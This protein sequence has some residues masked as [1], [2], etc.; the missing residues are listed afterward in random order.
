MVTEEELR[1]QYA[2]MTTDELLRVVSDKS[3]YT[4]LAIAVAKKE[5]RYRKVSES[6][7]ENLSKIVHD[8]EN[9]FWMDNCL[10]DLKILAKLAYYFILWLPRMRYYYQN[11]FKQEGYLLKLNQSN[12]YSLLGVVFFILTIIV[13][14]STGALISL[15]VWPVGFI[16][17]YLYDLFY[18][19]QRQINNFQKIK[20]EGEL[21]IEYL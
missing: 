13:S 15:G 1:E 19:K 18:N 6:E 7:I 4:E 17:T 20:E 11:N 21:P 12:Y 5:L 3:G 16:I 10:F 8:R 14:A 2:K 9:K